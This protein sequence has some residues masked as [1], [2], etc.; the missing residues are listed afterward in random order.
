MKKIDLTI[1]KNIKNRN[2]FLYLKKR[3]KFLDN[4]TINLLSYDRQAGSYIKQYN[5]EKNKYHKYGALL[6]SEMNAH[7]RNG[8]SLLEVGT[9]ECVTLLSLAKIINKKFEN[10]YYLGLDF[11]FSRLLLGKYFLEKHNL[12][13]SLFCSNMNNI[14][15][16]DNCVDIVFSNHGIEP[17]GGQ[18]EKILKEMLRV[19]N[20][21]VFLFEPIYELN[22]KKNRIRMDKF[23]Y[24]KKLYN[25]CKKLDCSI[26]KY[27]LLNSNHSRKSNLTGVIILK[28]KYSKIKKTK[29]K[30]LLTNCQLQKKN[31]FFY[32]K[33]PGI[34]YPIVNSIPLLL[35]KSAVMCSRILD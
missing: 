20:K 26:I 17:N 33:N 12:F 24:V 16:V 8:S 7:L 21:Y 28:K 3:Y 27:E 25:T 23:G 35:D 4:E 13:P 11:S 18:E 2:F 1:L 31:D 14:G 34:L 9:G 29:F 22:S 32:N 30:C 5:N 19:S 6:Y 15:L 10:I